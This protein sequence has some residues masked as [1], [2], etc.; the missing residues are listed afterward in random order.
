MNHLMLLPWQP[1]Y[2]KKINILI[3]KK[4]IY[5]KILIQVFSLMANKNN[6][7]FFGDLGILE[8]AIFFISIMLPIWLSCFFAWC[9]RYRPRPELNSRKSLLRIWEKMDELPTKNTTAKIQL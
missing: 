8:I 6:C 1:Y 3:I 9:F 2:E 5:K 7:S 4:I